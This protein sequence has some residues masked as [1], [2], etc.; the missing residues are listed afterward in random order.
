MNETVDNFHLIEFSVATGCKH[1]LD[2]NG[3][4]EE[5][6]PPIISNPSLYNRVQ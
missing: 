4:I 2:D 5:F 6:S 3:I 1:K